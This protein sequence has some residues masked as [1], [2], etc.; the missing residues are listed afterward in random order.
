M[1]SVLSLIHG[2][3]NLFCKH[4]LLRRAWLWLILLPM[5]VN[6]LLQ[7]AQLGASPSANPLVSEEFLIRS[8]VDPVLLA[9]STVLLR[10][11]GIFGST[12]VLE[13]GVALL[14]PRRAAE[15]ATFPSVLRR[16]AVDFFSVVITS[17]LRFVIASLWALLLIV[18]GIIYLLRTVF[19]A[20]VVVDEGAF[21]LDALRRSAQLTRGR[22]LRTWGTILPLGALLLGPP[23]IL[24]GV[25]EA[26][27]SPSVHAAGA[28]AISSLFSLGY[29]L[30]LLGLILLYGS[31]VDQSDTSPKV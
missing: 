3:W 9:L 19:Y 17:V 22:V 30:L 2:S 31:C 4:H 27:A 7:F 13:I 12:C 21:G 5:L 29:V 1:P 11:I 28:L 14:H 18:P 26:A 8:A 25:L 20:I 15:H 10:T 6:S 16:G 24:D 23:L